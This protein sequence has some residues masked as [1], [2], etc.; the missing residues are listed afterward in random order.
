[1]R[2]ANDS[3]TGYVFLAVAALATSA[4]AAS[5]AA[6]YPREEIHDTFV[7]PDE[8]VSN[9]R[10][11]NSRWPDCYSNE[12]AVRDIFR[13]EGVGTSSGSVPAAGVGQAQALALL[14][15]VC[16]LVS[17]KGGG[18]VYETD[19]AGKEVYV[20][21]PHKIF[22]AY[23]HHYCDGLGWVMVQLWR[24]SGQMGLDQCHHGHSFPS[25]RYRDADGLMRY[26]DFEPE[27]RSYYWDE[28]RGIVGTTTMPLLRA[29]VHRHLVQPQQIHT[30]RTSLRQGEARELLWDNQGH[31][32]QPEKQPKVIVLKPAFQYRPGRTDGVYG[33]V[34]QETQVFAPDL[35]PGAYR[36]AVFAAENV[37]CAEKPDSGIRLHP[38]EKG[39]VASVTYRLSSPFVAVDGVVEAKL[40]K[41]QDADVCRLML[42]RDDGKS[43]QQIASLEKAGAESVKVN[44]GLEARANDRPH[45]YTAYDLLLKA[46]FSSYSDPRAVGLG[47]L[48]VTTYR[49]LNK[50]ALPNLMPGENVFRVT[51]D[52][53]AEG[54]C[55]RLELAYSVGGKARRVEHTIASLP[56]YFAIDTGG[57]QEKWPTNFDEAF[58]VGQVRMKSITLRV[59]DSAN[60]QASASLSAGP[61]EEKFRL[62]YPHPVEKLLHPIVVKRP[63]QEIVQ[64]SG[65]FPQSKTVKHDKQ[66]M[67]AL[68]VKLKTGQGT[69]PWVAAEDL[70]ACPEAMDALLDVLPEA[71]AD[72]LLHLCKAF[73]QIKDKRAAGPLLEIWAKWHRHMPGSRHI[74]DVLAALVRSLGDM[75]ESHLG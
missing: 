3:T 1:M 33:A 22:T 65:F 24:A 28:G 68:V 34:G 72:L 56:F 10:I 11:A 19:K 71:N 37:A 21:D 54:Q 13:L 70:G 59:V 69:E 27:F 49:Q 38:A 44:I 41:G 60:A 6:D 43:W 29:H 61:C 8:A 36:S 57:V 12:S 53:L 67:E 64:T 16:I 9:L 2:N 62:A 35:T 42:S 52:K 51:A 75:A 14:K 63:E 74:P 25:L 66:A 39:K 4:V 26:H 40:A 45:V 17:T 55:L 73:A 5:P 7:G 47:E 30:L 46:E 32:I 20:Y 58:N 18:Y 50:R 15:W 48:R 23:G 31:V